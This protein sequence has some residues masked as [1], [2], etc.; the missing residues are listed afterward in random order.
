MTKIELIKALESVP[1]IEEIYISANG[2][3]PIMQVER[4]DG[5]AEGD[6]YLVADEDSEI[7]Y[8]ND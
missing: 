2:V 3:F 1:D 6:L 8:D 4:G 5:N 7:Y